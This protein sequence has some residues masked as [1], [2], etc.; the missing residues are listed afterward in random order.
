MGI[1]SK[2]VS[3]SEAVADKKLG[4]KLLV[5]YFGRE[6]AYKANLEAALNANK[7]DADLATSDAEHVARNARITSAL[8]KVPGL[9]AD[10]VA[11][12]ISNDINPQAVVNAFTLKNAERDAG[13]MSDAG[14]AANRAAEVQNKVLGSDATGRLETA[15]ELGQYTGQAG[16]W[17][18]KNR[19]ARGMGA[20]A[21]AEE[22]GR[23]TEQ[24]IVDE[25]R[26]RASKAQ[27]E[28][29]R[30]QAMANFMDNIGTNQGSTEDSNWRI[31]ASTARS[32][33]DSPAAREKLAQ[34]ELDQARLLNA[35]V[36]AAE[37]GAKS[38]QVMALLK[39]QLAT[40]DLT[41]EERERIAQA[42]YILMGQ[43]I[44]GTLQTLTGNS[45]YNKVT[46]QPSDGTRTGDPMTP[47]SP[48]PITPNTDSGQDN[49]P[50]ETDFMRRRR[51]LQQ[52]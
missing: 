31:K 44:Y 18:A 24:A 30:E 21:N 35:Q 5:P 25:A 1:F 40:G 33:A 11:G 45:I 29:A 26:L 36:S 32:L 46:G 8:G 20:S 34:V 9:N 13:A 51:M 48:I 17:D 10:M 52:R 39:E 43:P 4:F 49:L 47:R 50:G 28:N 6:M 19:V 38:E 14:L 41:A 23:A 12:I 22:A 27:N 37:A 7:L 3:P 15:E 42:L 16:L 2:T